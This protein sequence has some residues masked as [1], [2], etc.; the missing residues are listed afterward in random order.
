MLYHRVPR[1]AGVF[2][3]DIFAVGCIVQPQNSAKNRTAEMSASGIVVVVVVTV[4]VVVFIN[5][6]VC[7]IDQH[8]ELSGVGGV[9]R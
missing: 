8:R 5:L 2:T 9:S 7:Y 6:F 4:V 3:S 1:R